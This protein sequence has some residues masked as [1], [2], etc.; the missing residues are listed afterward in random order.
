MIKTYEPIGRIRRMEL[1][2]ERSWTGGLE[3][4]YTTSITVLLTLLLWLFIVNTSPA[5]G[6]E[7][8]SSVWM[9]DS[10]L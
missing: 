3:D 8:E 4:G 1:I 5:S 2:A 6:S 10:S 9:A 7:A